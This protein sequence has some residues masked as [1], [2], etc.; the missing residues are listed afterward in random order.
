MKARR[1]PYTRQSTKPSSWSF[2]ILS[3][4]MT[5][6]WPSKMWS[7]VMFSREAQTD[8]GAGPD[9]PAWHLARERGRIRIAEEDLRLHGRRRAFGYA[10]ERPARHAAGR[11]PRPCRIAAGRP[12]RRASGDRAQP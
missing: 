7:A 9:R 8:G 6:P 11:P 1:W 4:A 10:P 12:R 5:M 3:A 2:E